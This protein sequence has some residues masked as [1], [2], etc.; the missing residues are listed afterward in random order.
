METNPYQVVKKVDL[1]KIK[2]S[3]IQE[4]AKGKLKKYVRK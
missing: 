4:D 3:E 1:S 2:T